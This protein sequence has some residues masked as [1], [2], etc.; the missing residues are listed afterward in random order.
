MARKPLIIKAWTIEP[1]KLCN[2]LF[3]PGV[4]ESCVAP[5]HNQI[6]L[7]ACPPRRHAYCAKQT[8]NMSKL[9]G[10]CQ[11]CRPRSTHD[12]DEILKSLRIKKSSTSPY[13]TPGYVKRWMHI[14]KYLHK[15]FK[16]CRQVSVTIKD[17]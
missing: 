15:L 12:E 4:A 9:K 13:T 1:L 17:S 11:K 10:S 6:H 3:R 16:R 7:H 2:D 5:E 8:G 14:S